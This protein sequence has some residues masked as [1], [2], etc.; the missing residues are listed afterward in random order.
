MQTFDVD[1]FYH[2]YWSDHRL[3]KPS[4]EKALA[5]LPNKDSIPLFKLGRSWH[6]R[7]WLPDTYFRNAIRGS[8]SNILTPTQYIS[9]K[10]YTEIFM[11]VRLSLRLSCEMNFAKFPFDTQK[12]FINI[13]TSKQ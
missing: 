3:R 2:N 1:I 11:A 7:L 8:I 10:N 9:V 4:N 12:C 5:H 13:T 6:N